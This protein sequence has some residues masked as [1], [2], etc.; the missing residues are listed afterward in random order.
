[1]ENASGSTAGASSAA[2]HIYRAHRRTEL[3]R[4][5]EIEKRA[6]EDVCGRVLGCG[7]AV[8]GGVYLV[9]CRFDEPPESFLASYPMPCIHTPD[10]P[11]PPTSLP[12]QEKETAYRSTLQQKQA[13]CEA[14]TRKN[15]E[16]RRRKKEKKRMGGN[17]N[18][19]PQQ[20]PGGG[21]GSGESSGEEEE[22]EG[23]GRKKQQKRGAEAEG[24]AVPV[25]VVAIKDDG[26][27]LETMKALMGDGGKK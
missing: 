22:E 3:L 14:R 13:A 8:C 5:E 17:G 4:L 18:G 16:K 21:A 24:V 19:K 7:R 10:T 15:A 25:P 20:Q 26:S 23:R 12:Q 6:E 1:M 9:W 2:F 27:F 11:S